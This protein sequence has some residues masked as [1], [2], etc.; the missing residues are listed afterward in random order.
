M[1]KFGVC[2]DLAQAPLFF[3]A[4]AYVLWKNGEFELKVKRQYSRGG[5]G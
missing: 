3:F 4:A 5:D 1:Q 2:A